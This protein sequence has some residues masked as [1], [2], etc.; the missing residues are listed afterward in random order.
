MTY[1]YIVLSTHYQMHCFLSGETM[2]QKAV[3]TSGD[4]K[5]SLGLLPAAPRAVGSFTPLQ[6]A[7]ISSTSCCAD[8]GTCDM[9]AVARAGVML[10]PMVGLLG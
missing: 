6:S 2:F 3:L 7:L 8:T 4:D 10:I 9:A 5:H 1:M